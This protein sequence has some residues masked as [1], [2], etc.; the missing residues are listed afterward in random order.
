[1]TLVQPTAQHKHLAHWLSDKVPKKKEFTVAVDGL[2]NAGKSTLSRFI[3]WQIG[4]PVIETDLLM[5]PSEGT[6]KHDI[7]LL[8]RLIGMRHKMNRPIIV[9]GIFTLQCLDQAGIKPELLIRVSRKY[10]TR[11]GSWPEAFNSYHHQFPRSL[12]PDYDFSW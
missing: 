12:Q 7:E 8:T 4:A 5:L 9:V 1:M 10:F 3:A 2:D 11:K 6:P